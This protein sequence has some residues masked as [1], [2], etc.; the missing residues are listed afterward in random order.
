MD[1]VTVDELREWFQNYVKGYYCDIEDIDYHIRLKEEHTLRVCSIIKD[2]GIRINLDEPQLYLAEAIA[3]FHDI[4]RFEQY[5]R[6]RTFS[7]RKSEDHAVLGI[8]VLENSGILQAVEEKERNILIKAISCHNI[9]SLPAPMEP[10]CLMFCKLIRDADKVDI[11]YILIGYYEKPESYKNLNIGEASLPCG[12]SR[13]V[14]TDVLNSRMV[15]YEDV[16][17]SVDMKL[18]RLSWIFDINFKYTLGLIKEKGYAESIIS[19]L[20]NIEEINKVG[21]KVLDYV[22]ALILA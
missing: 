10:E 16:K 13:D 21:K 18:L 3:L 17:T 20:P 22:D 14:L 4:G 11:L 15:K 1:R 12:Y 5:K 9:L 6:Y 2:V 19:S 8:G 7:D